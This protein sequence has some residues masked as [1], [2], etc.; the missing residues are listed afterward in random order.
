MKVMIVKKGRG[1]GVGA[2]KKKLS[3]ERK[4]KDCEGGKDCHNR[5]KGLSV[6]KGKRVFDLPRSAWGVG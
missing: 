4:R 5:R 3:K 6:K 1:K 2:W